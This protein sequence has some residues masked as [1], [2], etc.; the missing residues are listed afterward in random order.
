MY[1]KEDGKGLRLTALGAVELVSPMQALAAKRVWG[2][3][4]GWSGGLVSSWALRGC[5]GVS[6]PMYL[7]VL[8]L[9]LPAGRVAFDTRICQTCKGYGERNLGPAGCVAF[10]Q[11]QCLYGTSWQCC[12]R[13]SDAQDYVCLHQQLVVVI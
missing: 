2:Q 12:L 8:G 7:V 11:P 3:S 9:S 6:L 4:V 5:Q 13:S 10:G 1:H